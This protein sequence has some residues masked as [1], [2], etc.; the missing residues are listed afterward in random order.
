MMMEITVSLLLMMSIII[1]IVKLMSLVKYRI[2]FENLMYFLS[3]V[4]YCF[5]KCFAK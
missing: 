5:C 3:K 4:C 2:V 1:V